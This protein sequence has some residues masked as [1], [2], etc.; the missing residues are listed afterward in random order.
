MNVC[1]WERRRGIQIQ[2]DGG[3]IAAQGI[4]SGQ[5]LADASVIAGGHNNRASARREAGD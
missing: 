3:V 2:S 1:R 4:S 5:V